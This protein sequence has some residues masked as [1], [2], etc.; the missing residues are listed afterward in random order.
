M[1]YD[2]NLFINNMNKYFFTALIVFSFAF[3]LNAQQNCPTYTL[4]GNVNT[5]TGKAIL[6]SISD[7]TLPYKA[8]QES[9]IINGKFIFTDSILYPSAFRLEIEINGHLK[10][11]SKM[12]FVD[13]CV[14]TLKCNIDSARGQVPSV[15]NNSMKEYM[16]DYK[17]SFNALSNN[18]AALNKKSNNLYK[19]Y[20]NNIPDNYLKAITKEK[21][22]IERANYLIMWQ[23]TKEHS[24]SYVSMWTLVWQLS[25]G[26]EPVLDTIYNSLSGHL[27]NTYTGKALAKKLA[28]AKKTM[29]GRS[30]LPLQLLNTKLEKVTLPQINK[31]RKY[32]LVT[33]W[34]GRCASCLNQ[35]GAYQRL[36][37]SYR[38]AGFE[39]IG[40]S[41]DLKKNA[42]DWNKVIKERGLFWPQYLD[43]GGGIAKHLSISNFPTNF[44]LNENGV[45]IKKDITEKEL[46]K[47]LDK[48][49]KK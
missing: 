41:V 9:R 8:T 6:I 32:T 18:W 5:D 12:F 4:Y 44:L 38:K 42:D 2:W 19:A 31:G 33:F 11:A 35:F 43:E 3:T 39:I 26:Y 40:I 10:Y 14:Q 13:P 49:L 36:Y 15:D 45:I 28:G 24:D 47:L 37:S 48:D 23:Y 20:Q 16:G 21:D 30:F 27:K 1:I 7:S 29:T 46:E 34:F 22:S 25:N 17:Q